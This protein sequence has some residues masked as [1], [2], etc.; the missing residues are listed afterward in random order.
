M[1]YKT[2]KRWAVGANIIMIILAICTLFPFLLLVSASFTDEAAAISSG[3]SLIMP[4]V[5]L[6]AYKYV[7]REWGQIGHAYLVTIFVTVVGT[8]I[9]LVITSMFAYGLSRN[10][11]F[12]KVINFLVIFSMLFNGGIVATYYTYSKLLNI[13]NTIWA[14]IVPGLLMNAMTVMLFKNYYQNSIP[15]AL[16]ESAQ[17]DG[18]GE[19]KVFSRIIVPLSK[20]IFAT[21]GLMSA[22]GYWN[23]W[24]NG[25]YYLDDPKLFGIQTVLNKINENVTYLATNASAASMITDMGNMPSNTM[26]MAMAVLGILPILAVYPFFQDYFA[27]GI[28]FGAVK[29]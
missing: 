20:P 14:L 9:S 11:P 12:G 26:R 4:K 13:R 16:M 21:M 5:S 6:E 24:G 28:V 7:L 17:L 25:L 27:K 19:I 8:T 29:E 18:A 22:L 1:N 10:I 15:K 23:D 2:D 3:Y